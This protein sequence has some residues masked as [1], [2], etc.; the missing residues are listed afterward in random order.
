[1]NPYSWF[2][3]LTS[4]KPKKMKAAQPVQSV[5]PTNPISVQ[6]Q[7]SLWRVSHEYEQDVIFL[8][9]SG[10]LWSYHNNGEL[11]WYVDT[12][13]QWNQKQTKDGGWWWGGSPAPNDAFLNSPVVS[14]LTA[15]R[16]EALPAN[17][18]ENI[19]CVGSSIVLVSPNGDI[20]AT[21][22]L[23]GGVPVSLPTV[24]DFNNDG[25]TDVIVVTPNAYYGYALESTT[26]SILFPALV[27]LLLGAMAFLA[28]YSNL[29][30]KH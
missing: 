5:T 29:V 3:A 28:I 25:L 23:P 18:V 8:V 11:N 15:F 2:Q 10:R 9:S 16:T 14:S 24:G 4:R 27:I 6:S 26:G 22:A 21:T 20:L 1:M 30:H 19:L 7:Q 12:A 13:A 17:K